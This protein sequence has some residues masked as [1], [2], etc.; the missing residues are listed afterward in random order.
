[1]SSLI[2]LRGDKTQA[3]VAKKLGISNGYLSLLE[4][5][6]RKPSLDVVNKMSKLYGVTLEEI[7]VA[8]EFSIITSEGKQNFESCKG[9]VTNC[10]LC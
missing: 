7:L 1:M 5:G 6:K 4:H 10:E 2:A 9:E 3:E 8:Y